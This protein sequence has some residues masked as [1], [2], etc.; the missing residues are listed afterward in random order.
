MEQIRSVAVIG[1][2]DRG[3]AFALRCAAHGFNTSLQ[4]VLSSRLRAVQSLLTV[5]PSTVRQNLHLA[6]S[7]ESAVR[8]ADVAIDFVPDE[9][10][11]KLEIFSLLDRMAPPKTIFCTPTQ[12]SIT[13]LGS[14]TYRAD[15]CFALTLATDESGDEAQVL[16]GEKAAAD[17]TEALCGWL[18]SLGFAVT[19]APDRH[20]I[21][22]HAGV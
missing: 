17:P 19:V 14:C 7:I 8:E 13:D 15:R 16:Q 6:S 21:A 5:A 1:A 18:R 20:V 9:L 11:S 3:R 22:A 2:G 12:L 4:D 10:E